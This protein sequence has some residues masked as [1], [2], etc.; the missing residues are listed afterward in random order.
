MKWPSS[1]AAALKT[2]NALQ[3]LRIDDAGV[4]P[5]ILACVIN[6]L[7]GAGFYYAYQID[8]GMSAGTGGFI[9]VLA[10]F[11]CL[12][13]PLSQGRALPRIR[14]W[15]GNRALWLWAFFGVLTTSAYYLSIPLLG[16]GLSMFL[17]A[18]SGIFIVA[19][20][21]LLAGQRSP[22]FHWFGVLGSFAGL[23]LLGQSANGSVPA[24]GAL[25]A[26]LSGLFGGLAMLMVARAR[27]NY[28]PDSI[29]FHWTIANCLAYA[30]YFFF[31]PPT[32][33][34]LALTW[35]VLVVTGLGAAASQYLTAVSYQRSSASFVACLSYLTPIFSLVIDA[36]IFGFS[37]SRSAILGAALVLGFG[38]VL[39]ILGGKKMHGR[40][41]R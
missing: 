3:A 35:G 36:C 40:F 24:V 6:A 32:F 18:G 41:A 37:F 26:V 11:S 31:T 13:I 15:H 29:M 20:A 30:G 14:A 1:R 4:I 21:P 17:N 23:F 25:L 5:I 28:S 27:K 2:R 38:L 39:P 33:P 10:N 16:A 22:L 34:S 7:V 9:R 19:L 8:P 12:L